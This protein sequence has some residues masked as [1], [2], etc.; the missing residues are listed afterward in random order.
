[1][2][3]QIDAA[4]LEG[5]DAIFGPLAQAESDVGYMTPEQFASEQA[6]TQPP[7]IPT[8]TKIQPSGAGYAQERLSQ[9]L[10]PMYQDVPMSGP[11]QWPIK[12][13]LGD[14]APEQK[15][16]WR[17]AMAGLAGGPAAVLQYRQ[18]L[19]Q[20][21]QHDDEAP[22]RATE[23]QLKNLDLQDRMDERKERTQGIRDTKDPNSKISQNAAS[24]YDAAMQSYASLIGRNDPAYAAEL[25]KQIGSA[26]GQD[27]M[28]IDRTLA[29]QEKA[30]ALK[31]QLLGM[32]F[33]QAKDEATRKA[34]AEIAATNAANIKNDNAL[35]W[36][37]LKQRGKEHADDLEAKKNKPA[38]NPPQTIVK[39]Q[40]QRDVALKEISRLNQLL[41]TKKVRYTGLGAESA[42]AI[43]SALPD[44]IDPRTPEEKEFSGLVNRLRAPER[45]KIFG[46]ALS[47]YDKG[48]AN[49]F[50]A[51]LGNNPAQLK[52][53]L[54]TLRTV[55]EDTNEATR[56]SYP[57]LMNLTNGNLPKTTVE[58]GATSPKSGGESNDMA[59]AERAQ[60]VL[61]D[62]KESPKNKA[63]AQAYLD[64]LK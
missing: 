41:D 5:K 37:N 40:T 14:V 45:N 26:R 57:A 24:D 59:K 58:A 51:N 10:S 55:L 33:N 62:P 4:E 27:K 63:G 47:A 13:E 16:D 28:S 7:P 29:R 50:M 23:R 49:T 64:S 32:D 46:A 38:Q 18:Q 2:R 35:G 60:K 21:K 12:S 36:A 9:P 52:Q 15:F 30:I 54:D 19:A 43:V 53:N 31:M 8:I 20:Q 56:Q 6:A 48:D 22:D 42:N 34:Q 17:G 44:A 39:D 3:N 1:M 61:K 11:R 25:Q